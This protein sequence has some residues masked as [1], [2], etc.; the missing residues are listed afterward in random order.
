MTT[1]TIKNGKNISRTQFENVEELLF[2]F[3]DKMGLGILLPL[4]KEALT[5]KRK[6]QFKKALD[7]PKSKMLNI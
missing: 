1:I 4:E 6:K 3:M 5:L 2:H 7:T